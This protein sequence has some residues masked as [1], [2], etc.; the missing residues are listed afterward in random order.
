MTEKV[1]AFGGSVI[2][3]NFESLD[4]IAEALEENEDFVAV[5]GAGHLKKHQDAVRDKC[6]NSEVDMVG[7][8]ATR[9]NA[10]TLQALLED[11]SPQTPETVEEV[12]TIAQDRNVVMGGLNPGFSTD[13][14]A[15]IVAELL[16]AE[17]YFVTDIDGIY[18]SDPEENAE[19]EKMDSV[20]TEKLFEMTSGKNVPGVYSVI[21]ETAVQIIQRSE[22]RSK[23]VEGKP[24]NI[25]DPENCE[26]T[27]IKPTT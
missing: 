6:N 23:L 17:L 12:K 2:S 1:F 4:R 15:A 8:E 9:L 24:E 22:I 14:V 19:A 13:A 27:E 25:S 10:K 5:V 21:D 3:E 7:I 11:V 18:T 26:G 16:E 20:E